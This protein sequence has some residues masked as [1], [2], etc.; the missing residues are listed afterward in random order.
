MAGGTVRVLS[1]PLELLFGAGTCAGM[2]DGQL[3]SRFVAGRDEAGELAFEALV[4]R[5]GPMILR[6]CNQ[7]LDHPDDVHDALQAVF[8]VLAER[9]NSIRSRESV[10]SWLYGVALR[11]TARARVVAIRRRIRDRRTSEA[12]RDT[13]AIAHAETE[14]SPIERDDR[15]Q[16]LHQEVG[17][18]PERYRAPIVLCYLEGLTHDEAAARLSWPVGTVRS[19]LSRGRDTLRHRLSRRGVTAT[20]VGGPLGVW[21]TGEQ[22]ASA[23]EAGALAAGSAGVIPSKLSTVLVKMVSQVVAGQP[24]AGWSLH[25]GALALA[26]GVLN[27]MALKKFFVMVGIAATLAAITTGGGVLWIRTSHAQDTKGPEAKSLPKEETK[28]AAPLGDLAE[29]DT[30]TLKRQLLEVARRRYEVQIAAYVKGEISLDG[31]LGASDELVQAEMMAATSPDER[32]II[33]RQSLARLTDME[34]RAAAA[35]AAGQVSQ[36]E[37]DGFIL[38]RIQAELDLKTF[39]SDTPD[40]ASILRRLSDLE[41]KVELLQKIRNTPSNTSKAP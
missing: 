6:I 32:A 25:A 37:V 41:R 28:K 39:A 22:L 2:S 9:A 1:E 15:A 31:V 16:I 23:A 38:R 21:L 30:D 33:R 26:Q 4:L 7:A 34:A 12:A 3:L 10:G 17:R 40:M 19:R 11:V 13:T 36:R 20:A 5:H 35:R 27:M 29:K 24:P 14:P 8:L 18:L